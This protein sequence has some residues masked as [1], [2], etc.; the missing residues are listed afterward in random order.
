MA[1]LIPT[2][3]FIDGLNLYHAIRDLGVPALKWLNVRALVEKFA[4]ANQYSL[5]RILYVTA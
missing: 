3:A 4:P 1:D 2:V 5:N